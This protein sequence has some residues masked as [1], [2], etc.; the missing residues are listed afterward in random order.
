MGYVDGAN[1]VAGPGITHGL[2]HDDRFARAQI[3]I[4]I[5]GSTVAGKDGTFSI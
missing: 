3:G 4:G 1:Q 5:I 2:G